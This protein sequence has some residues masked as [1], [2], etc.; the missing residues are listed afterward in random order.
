M[1]T[2]TLVY[3]YF[4]PSNDNSIFRFPP[5]GL[6]YIAAHLK[7]KGISVELVDCTFMSLKDAIER[8]RNSHSPDNRHTSNVFDE[9]KGPPNG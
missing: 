1:T 4:H 2:V 6:G 8:I 7:N 5:L 3:P 9:R